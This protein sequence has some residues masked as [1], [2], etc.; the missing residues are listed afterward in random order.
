MIV[1][2]YPFHLA[3]VVSGDDDC[4]HDLW[5]HR[6]KCTCRAGVPAVSEARSEIQ[7]TGAWQPGVSIAAA[8][9]ENELNDANFLCGWSKT[10][11]N[12]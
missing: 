3:E 1:S 9:L 11:Q 8:A 12:Q 7:G 5:A 6:P 4:V 2:I 10:H